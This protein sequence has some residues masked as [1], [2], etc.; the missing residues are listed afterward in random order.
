MVDVDSGKPPVPASESQKD[1]SP[2]Q[3]FESA[4]V[5]VT[6]TDGSMLFGE[7]IDIGDSGFVYLSDAYFIA[8]GKDKSDVNSLR[9]FGNEVH[10]PLPA[11]ELPRTS[12][13]MMQSLVATSPVMEAIE[14]FE[15]DE[16]AKTSEA[17]LVDKNGH[18]AVF[19][20]DTQVF[21]GALE[22]ADGYLR[23]K[24]AHY[25]SF[26]DSGAAEVG[27][28]RSLDD[29]A[30]IPQARNVIAPSGDLEVPVESVLYFQALSDESPVVE[31]L[32]K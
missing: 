6:V 28:I 15:K 30:L 21:F 2:A 32:K 16:P 29:V 22:V 9:R 23:I 20:K 1:D 12:V 24:N 8:K 19:L 10:R 5:A 14:S 7:R 4:W 13:S 26:K 3:G 31:A 17:V 11:V 25:L 18:Y 27:E